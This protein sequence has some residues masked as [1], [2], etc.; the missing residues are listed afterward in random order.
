MN[1]VKIFK[2]SYLCAIVNNMSD[3]KIKKDNI[4]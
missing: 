4:I 1:L 2:Y 3:I